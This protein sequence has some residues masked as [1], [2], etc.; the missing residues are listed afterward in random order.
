MSLQIGVVQNLIGALRVRVA[1]PVLSQG[2]KI[3]PLWVQV[4]LEHDV[5][6]ASIYIHMKST[7]VGSLTSVELMYTPGISS[8]NID[9]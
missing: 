5:E 4:L 2:L 6:P 9:C 1:T 8:S 7:I 3:R